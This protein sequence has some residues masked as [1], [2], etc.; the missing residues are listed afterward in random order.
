MIDGSVVPSAVVPWAGCEVQFA[1]RGQFFHL[2]I[3]SERAV[4]VLGIVESAGDEHRDFYVDEV[5]ARVSVDPELV[6]V[7][8][9]H[10]V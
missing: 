6:A 9:F 7:R 10:H 4:A 2:V 5:Q 8:V 1:F 3:C